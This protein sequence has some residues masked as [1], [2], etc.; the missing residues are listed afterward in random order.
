MKISKEE[1]Q[2]IIKEEV[3]EIFGFGKKKKG[4]KEYPATELTTLLGMIQKA[5][6][7]SGVKFKGKRGALVDEFERILSQGGFKL[8]EANERLFIGMDGNIAINPDDAPVLTDFLETLK[9][10]APDVFKQLA[11]QMNNYRFDLPDSGTEEEIPSITTVAD[12]DPDAPDIPAGQVQMDLSDEEAPSDLTGG[13]EQTIQTISRKGNGRL[14]A[15]LT[16]VDAAYPNTPAASKVAIA[17]DK[18]KDA[19]ILNNLPK[20][21]SLPKDLAQLVTSAARNDRVRKFLQTQVQTLFKKYQQNPQLIVSKAAAAA[22]QAAKSSEPETPP[23]DSAPDSGLKNLKPGEVMVALNQLG[24]RQGTIERAAK[25]ALA[26]RGLTKADRENIEVVTKQLISYLEGGLKESKIVIGP[27]A[28]RMIEE[29]YENRW[30]E[31]AG[32][33]WK[34]QS[35]KN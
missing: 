10:E 17:F 29:L 6:R 3:N 19:N 27:A 28:M 33:K 16:I 22:Q 13:F 30:K 21:D 8:K 34:N 12:L 35:L 2:K 18:T 7:Q 24:L 14:K 31:I 32:I 5:S 9:S 20:G 11:K 26:N 1:L 23:G 15:F 25:K 4:S